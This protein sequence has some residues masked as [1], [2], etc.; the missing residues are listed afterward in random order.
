M[1]SR[2]LAFLPSKFRR[3]GWGG[4]EGFLFFFPWFPMF[5]LYVPFMFPM[6]SQLG[7]VGTPLTSH[8]RS[9]LLGS[10]L[11]GFPIVGFPLR[12][13]IGTSP[14]TINIHIH[15]ISLDPRLHY[16]P[17]S[18]ILTTLLGDLF[19]CLSIN[20]L[21]ALAFFQQHISISKSKLTFVGV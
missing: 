15:I 11:V 5:S 20:P 14:T 10:H 12:T 18:C 4:G 21:I 17:K 6:G 7:E 19:F 13:R 16:I 8:L 2:C 9:R 1:H 3:V